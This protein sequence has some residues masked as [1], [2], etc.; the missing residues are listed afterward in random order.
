MDEALRRDLL[1]LAI[2]SSRL[3]VQLAQQADKHDGDNISAARQQALQKLNEAEEMCGSS[4]L[5][6]LARR[7]YQD[8]AS[9][10]AGSVELNGLSPS[11]N[12]WEHYAIGRWLMEHGAMEDAQRQFSLAIDLDPSEFW[13]NFEQTCCDFELG[14]FQRALT[15]ASVCI[16]L[17]PRQ[18]EC[19]YN[20][21]L[22]YQS[23]DRNDEALADFGRA[24]QLDKARAPALLARGRC[25]VG[26]KGMR[27]PKRIWVP[28]WRTAA[29]LAMSIINW[30]G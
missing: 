21:A 14:H 27:S 30:L 2:L 20:R 16:A 7:D 12:A 29:G 28:R 8:A 11:A 26:C 22:C 4:V 13:P 10:T 15:S 17:A 25:W 1:D 23:L 3:D 9:A 18:A 19:F 5:F 6:N 24:L